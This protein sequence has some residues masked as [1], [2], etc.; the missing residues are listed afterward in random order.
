M[1]DVSCRIVYSNPYFAPSDLPADASRSICAGAAI[2]VPGFNVRALPKAQDLLFLNRHFICIMLLH[3]S[4]GA[5]AQLTSRGEGG[6]SALTNHFYTFS[7][8]KKPRATSLLCTLQ[9]HR[10]DLRSMPMATWIVTFSGCLGWGGDSSFISAIS[11]RCSLPGVMHTHIAG[12]SEVRPWA[13]SVLREQQG[14]NGLPRRR[15]GWL[16]FNIQSSLRS[17]VPGLPG[18]ALLASRCAVLPWE[19]DQLQ[20]LAQPTRRRAFI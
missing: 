5:G 2:I 14:S 4:R 11:A 3:P 17:S 1:A 6:G 18:C 13:S 9:G 19:P 16:G 15:P 12:A 20:G 8:I 7:G 10:R